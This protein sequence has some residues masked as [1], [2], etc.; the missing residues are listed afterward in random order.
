MLH[1]AIWITAALVLGLWSVAAWLLVEAA[2]RGPG[3]VDRFVDW[4]ARQPYG[5][6]LDE[7][8]VGWQDLLRALADL[9]QTLLGALGASAPWWPW[10][11]WAVGVVA[12]LLVASVFSLIVVALTPARGA[13]RSATRS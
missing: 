6:W 7:W 11:L 8:F 13:A 1:A 4:A 3:W 5:R 10:L 9:M 12:V 2:R